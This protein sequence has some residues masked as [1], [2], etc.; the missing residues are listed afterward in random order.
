MDSGCSVV[1]YAAIVVQERLVPVCLHAGTLTIQFVI[2]VTSKEIKDFVVHCAIEP[3]EHTHTEKWSNV[4]Y[5]ASKYTIN[6]A[7]N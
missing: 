4:H 3:T 5:V 6:L 2:R 7:I 1:A